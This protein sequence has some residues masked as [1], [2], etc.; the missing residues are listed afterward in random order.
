LGRLNGAQSRDG[1]ANQIKDAMVTLN[2][3]NMLTPRRAQ[4]T[5]Y[6][7]RDQ[8]TTAREWN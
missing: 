6:R 5:R 4:L 1:L 8:A 3:Q 2:R 7:T